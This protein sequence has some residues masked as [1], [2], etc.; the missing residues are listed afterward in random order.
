MQ[1]EMRL[2]KSNEDMSKRN[3]TDSKRLILGK[4]RTI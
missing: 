1:K 3:K 2:Q 4:G